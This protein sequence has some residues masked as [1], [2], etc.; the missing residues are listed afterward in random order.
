MH[1]PAEVI[2]VSALFLAIF[3]LQIGRFVLG[4][5]GL[6]DPPPARPLPARPLPARA[7]PKPARRYR[8]LPAARSN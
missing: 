6:I 1:F 2:A 3:L 8:P 4:A 5:V 7:V